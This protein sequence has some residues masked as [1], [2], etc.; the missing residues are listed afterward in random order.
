MDYI[1]SLMVATF[2]ALMATVCLYF[3]GLTTTWAFKAHLLLMLIVGLCKFLAL[4]LIF[5]IS[6]NFNPVK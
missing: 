6:R 5:Y 3:A 2:T 4:V 1:V